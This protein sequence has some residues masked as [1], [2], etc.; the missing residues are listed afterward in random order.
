MEIIIQTMKWI[1]DILLQEIAI[2]YH[3]DN[4]ESLRSLIIKHDQIIHDGT[5]PNRHNRT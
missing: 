5:L 4:D 3:L 2:D 1:K